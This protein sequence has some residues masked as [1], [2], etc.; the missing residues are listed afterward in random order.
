MTAQDKLKKLSALFEAA[1]IEAAPKE[2]EMLVAGLLGISKVDLLLKNIPLTRSQSDELDALAKRRISGEPMQYIL[3]YVEFYGL[4]IHVGPGVL[5]PRPETEL[6]VEQVIKDRTQKS[7]VKEQGKMD[8]LDLCTGS[9]CIALALANNF[10]HAQVYGV[11]R[12]DAALKY[13]TKNAAANSIN[14]VRFLPGD[15]YSP[16]KGMRFDLIVSNPP[17]IPKDDIHTLQKE[18]TDHEPMLALDGGVD[19]LDFYRSILAE[20]SQY[21]NVGGMVVLEIGIDQA[22]DIKQLAEDAGFCNI[23]F[24]KD[25]SGIERIAVVKLERQ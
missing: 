19:G 24:I 1:G 14:N 18:I 15:L 5:I 25:Y 9:G 23:R 8:I 22:K 13:A 3:G 2:A 12:S 20:A 11:D 10:P 21:L 4:T 6:L 16:V 7:E 17:Y